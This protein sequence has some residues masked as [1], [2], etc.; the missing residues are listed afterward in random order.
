[1]L[2]SDLSDLRDGTSGWAEAIEDS[3]GLVDPT[4]EVCTGVYLA[5]HGFV[6]WL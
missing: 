4:D 5:V 3:Q 2:N 1:M 6:E